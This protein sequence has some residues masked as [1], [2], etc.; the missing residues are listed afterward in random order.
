MLPEAIKAEDL[1]TLLY[2]IVYS[3]IN[4]KRKKFTSDKLSHRFL[5]QSAK[6]DTVTDFNLGFANKCR[7]IILKTA[8]SSL[9]PPPLY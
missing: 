4:G 9:L 1:D 6:V 2:P 5:I 3:I 7:N 8:L